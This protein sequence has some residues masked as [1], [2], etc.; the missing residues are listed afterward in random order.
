[1]SVLCWGECPVCCGPAWGKV[2]SAL[3][4]ETK[5][6]EKDA[7]VW[8]FKDGLLK[9]IIQFKYK[10]FQDEKDSN[11]LNTIFIFLGMNLFK[12]TWFDVKQGFFLCEGIDTSHCVTFCLFLR[13]NVHLFVH[14]F[15]TDTTI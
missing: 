7:E 8:I 11:I 2:C 5:K 13:P 6:C 9:Y 12:V 4:N 15:Y 10:D 14:C 3:S 1:L